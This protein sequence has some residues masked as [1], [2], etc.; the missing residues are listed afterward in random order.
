M[1]CV[2]RHGFTLIELLVVIAII[3]VL[4]S[5]LLP[6]VQQAREAARRTQCRNN[7]KQ[8][9]LA[10]HNYESSYNQIP[11]TYVAVRDSILHG[12]LGVSGTY[13]D[14]NIHV[15]AEYLLP[16]IDQANIANQITQTAPFFSPVDLSAAGLPNYTANN[17]A[18]IANVVSTYICPSAPASNNLLDI[19]NN[20]LVRD[21]HA[22]YPLL[23]TYRTGRMDYSP[24]S[25]MWGTP[26]SLAPDEPYPAGWFNGAMSNNLPR[27][28]LAML[29]DGSSNVMLMH[30]LAGRND[31]YIFG[32]KQA[33]GTNGG[34]WG[35]IQNAENWLGGSTYDG[36]NE[37]GPC[38]VNCSNAA[39]QG[40][41]SFHA[42]TVNI[43][44]GDGSVRG[45]SQ[46]VHGGII[47]KL[48]STSGGGVLGE[49]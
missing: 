31:L 27:T 44:L 42:G 21:T 19:T 48:V 18:A 33:T 12:D 37:D 3:A 8:I 30:E 24:S 17:K 9:G 22:A 28:R 46:N 13:D 35:D 2:R 23:V 47:T 16:Y 25:G 40:M 26:T 4:I 32:K 43:L 7:L 29:T 45:L 34:G 5:L 1:N 38:L 20:N 6:A 14:F 49:F 39:H 10:F 36:L 11:P 41:Y 15:Y